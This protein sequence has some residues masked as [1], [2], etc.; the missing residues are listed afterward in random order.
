MACVN[1][2]R[3]GELT[4]AHLASKTDEQLQIKL[5]FGQFISFVEMQSETADKVIG[6]L[7][8]DVK[9]KMTILYKVFLRN[10]TYKKNSLFD[11]GNWNVEITVLTGKYEKLFHLK[12]SIKSVKKLEDREETEICG[13]LVQTEQ[14]VLFLTEK[15]I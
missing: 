14:E 11:L 5:D 4:I 8:Y 6:L 1:K 10:N 15:A 3:S 9:N 7:G 12:D 13:L 2:H